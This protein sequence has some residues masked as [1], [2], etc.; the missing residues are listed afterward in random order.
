M[1]FNEKN[2]QPFFEFFVSLQNKHDLEP[3]DVDRRAGKKSTVETCTQLIAS[4]I[5]LKN[6][7]KHILL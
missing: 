6:Q 3:K 4:Y 1:H 2:R 5:C 7:F